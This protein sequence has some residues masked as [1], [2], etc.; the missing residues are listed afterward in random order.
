MT[1]ADQVANPCFWCGLPAIRQGTKLA[2]IVDLLDSFP[3]E[4]WT[5]G[6]ITARVDVS[7]STA[8][9]TVGR[10]RQ[11]GLIEVRHGAVPAYRK[12]P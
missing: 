6:E 10:L 9:T 11:V 2:R 4:W 1:L 8:L 7:R 5:V 12:V 3:D